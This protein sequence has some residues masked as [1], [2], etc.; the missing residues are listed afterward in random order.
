[1][2]FLE[3]T[4]DKIKRICITK[5]CSRKTILIQ[6][7]SAEEPNHMDCAKVHKKMRCFF[8]CIKILYHEKVCDPFLYIS[9]P[10]THREARQHGWRE[11]KTQP[12]HRHSNNSN[13]SSSRNSGNSKDSTIEPQVDRSLLF[14][15]FAPVCV[16]MCLCS[17]V[18]IAFSLIMDRLVLQDAIN[19]T[20][21]NHTQTIQS[22]H[23]QMLNLMEYIQKKML[24]L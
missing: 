10:H 9:I 5:H 1:M 15:L 8:S 17:V 4:P 14:T 24:S 2:E 13:S 18:C 7:K 23:Q 3:E 16:F 12:Q 22:V 21:H 19:A 20:H 11:K 6:N